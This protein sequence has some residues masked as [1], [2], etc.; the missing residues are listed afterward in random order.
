MLVFFPT[1]PA[2]DVDNYFPDL[3]LELKKSIQTEVNS[4]N[5]LY[6]VIDTGHA[7]ILEVPPLKQIF[8][9]SIILL[10]SIWTDFGHLQTLFADWSLQQGH[11]KDESKSQLQCKRIFQN[12][13]KPSP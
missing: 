8:L 9:R 6:N 11:S 1:A 5:S 3:Q 13:T 12:S 2:T 10:F 7:T 4:L